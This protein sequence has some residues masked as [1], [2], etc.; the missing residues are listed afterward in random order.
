MRRLSFS[1][2][3]TSWHFVPNITFG[4]PMVECLRRCIGPDPFFGEFQSLQNCI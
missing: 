4:H 1:N 2:R 3:A